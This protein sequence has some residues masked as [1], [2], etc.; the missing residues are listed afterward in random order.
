MAVNE[1]YFTRMIMNHVQP[2]PVLVADQKSLGYLITMG[3]P[4]VKFDAESYICLCH[5][6]IAHNGY[7]CPRCGCKI[8]N[9]PADCPVCHLTLISSSHL[10]R[11]YHHLFPVIPFE[12]VS[13]DSVASDVCLG[14]DLE[15]STDQGALSKSQCPKCKQIF[16]SSCD[17]FIHE[18]LHNCPGCLLN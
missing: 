5:N 18:R 13:D 16:C 14:C 6:R 11:S 8:C 7:C 15:F 4:V 12:P 10:A 9:I 2:P 3:F 17:L 1:D